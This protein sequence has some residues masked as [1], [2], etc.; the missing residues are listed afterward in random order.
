MQNITTNVITV[1]ATLRLA[2]T[3]NQITEIIW[4]DISLCAHINYMLLT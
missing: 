3:W 4:V 2:F 1:M